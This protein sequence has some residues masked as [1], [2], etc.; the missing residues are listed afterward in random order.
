M[1]LRMRTTVVSKSKI[2]G[3]ITIS[4]GMF[5]LILELILWALISNNIIKGNNPNYIFLT[6]LGFIIP[7]AL[8]ILGIVIVVQA[9][10]E[11]KK[12]K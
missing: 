10:K 2:S 8:I 4:C 1:K 11:N 12:G 7:L 3:I 9:N 6:I 5:T